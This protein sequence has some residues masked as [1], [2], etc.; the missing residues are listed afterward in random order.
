MTAAVNH[1]QPWTL[2][3]V[4]ALP[5]D[6]LRYELIDGVLIVNPPPAPKH[7]SVSYLLHRLLDDAAVAAGAA[8]R[9]YEGVGV[10]LPDG[11]LLI[12][13]LVVVSADAPSLSQAL[14]DPADVDL[15]VEVVSPGSRRRDRSVKPYMYAEAG[16]PH[17]WRIETDGYRGRTKELPVLA[18]HELVELG[19]Y[20]VVETVGAGEQ[21]RV[22]GPFPVTF[23]PAGLLS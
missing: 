10:R 12:P 19:E 9:I 6:G 15:A 3:E 13:D 17:Y 8:V 23:D 7:Q 21:L 11:N 14:L 22:D 20:R 18:R 1:P 5:E 2:D 16:I 4:M